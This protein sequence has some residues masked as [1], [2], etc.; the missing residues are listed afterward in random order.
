V[1]EIRQADGSIVKEYLLNDPKVIQQIKNQ[2][3]ST[4]NPVRSFSNHNL[5]KLAPI[6]TTNS[7]IN[8]PD[9]IK[10]IKSFKNSTENL[11]STKISDQ[12]CIE[13]INKTNENFFGDDF[14]LI[15]S[16]FIDL[17]NSFTTNYKTDIYK[18]DDFL[19]TNT[20]KILD[21]KF[22]MEKFKET[23]I[24]NNKE[25]YERP[26]KEDVKDILNFKSQTFH[27]LS[28]KQC[29]EKI[30]EINKNISRI[31]SKDKEIHRINK[32]E[33]YQNVEQLRSDHLY[34]NGSRNI[35]NEKQNLNEKNIEETHDGANLNGNSNL[36]EYKGT[37]FQK[38]FNCELQKNKI[39]NLVEKK[40]DVKHKANTLNSL[41]IPDDAMKNIIITKQQQ[42]GID[43][44]SVFES[45]VREIKDQMNH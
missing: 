1:N 5:N 27:N 43:L 19:N 40:T 4:N 41:N 28:T 25:K 14:E 42:L 35:K 21:S 15:K 16:K 26:F 39:D 11:S 8:N 3:K 20:E 36:N 32:I 7:N 12:N 17:N 33:D 34:K 45:Y 22:F 24:P 30:L 29:E 6:S 13:F 38:K 31:N 10:E 18:N 37:I 23:S 44:L 2:V 9:N